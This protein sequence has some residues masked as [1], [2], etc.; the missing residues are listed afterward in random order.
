M[1]TPLVS[2]SSSPNDPLRGMPGEGSC[3]AILT[4]TSEGVDAILSS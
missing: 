2:K 4:E 1:R 3:D